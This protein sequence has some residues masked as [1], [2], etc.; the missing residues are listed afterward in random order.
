[1]KTVLFA[2]TLFL[3]AAAAPALASDVC[4]M[5]H[6]VDRWSTRDNQS[7]V[8]D[9]RYG[10]KYLLSL[11]GMCSDLNFSFDM[12]I[13]PPTGMGDVCVDRGDRIVM[14]GGGALPHNDSCWITKVE[15]YTP[16][17]QAAYKAELEAKKNQHSN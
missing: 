5:R 3:A 7:M 8:V 4:L 11:T 15:R 2:A 17:M 1:M 16:E 6:D 12:A 13:H 9:D 14:R 10:R